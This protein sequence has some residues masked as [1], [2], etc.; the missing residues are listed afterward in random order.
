VGAP[1]S[2][3]GSEVAPDSLAAMDS[4]AAFLDTDGTAT[5]ADGLMV[6]VQKHDLCIRDSVA[7]HAAWHRLK[8]HPW[9]RP[10][11]ALRHL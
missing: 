7:Q 8:L 9:V 6:G 2:R 10:C 3:P 1:A 11:H 4:D 5:E